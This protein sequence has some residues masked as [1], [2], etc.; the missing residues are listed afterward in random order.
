MAHV[1][2]LIGGVVVQV[3]VVDNAIADP[4][5]WCIDRFGGDWKQTSYTGRI[6]GKFAGIGD[7]YD[8]VADMFV[9]QAVPLY[10]AQELADTLG[11]FGGSTLT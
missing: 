7:T 9:S 3:I 10:G 11:N 6:R 5:Q 4:E 2:Q 8:A 1:A